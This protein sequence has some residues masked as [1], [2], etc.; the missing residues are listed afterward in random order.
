MSRWESATRLCAR[1]RY[2]PK[3]IL[4]YGDKLTAAMNRDLSILRLCCTD[5]Q[6]NELAPVLGSSERN[7]VRHHVRGYDRLGGHRSLSRPNS[8]EEE[9]ADT[10]FA[11][12]DAPKQ[13]PTCH[14]DSLM[15][16]QRRTVLVLQQKGR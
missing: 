11:S 16:A 5:H 3:R 15:P 1:T 12:V 6:T 13:Q 8:P 7:S 2:L 9:K 4:K 10:A 14:T